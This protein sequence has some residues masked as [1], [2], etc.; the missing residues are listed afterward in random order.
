MLMEILFLS[1]D[2]C[3]DSAST[4]IEKLSEAVTHAR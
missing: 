3:H 4:G 1:L 2:P